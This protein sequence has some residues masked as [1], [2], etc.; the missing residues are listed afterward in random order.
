MN[1]GLWGLL[2]ALAFGG[3]D[4]CGRL[5]GRALGPRLTM[6]GVMA[7]GAVLFS[8]QAWHGDGLPA[9]S[10]SQAA[11]VVAAGLA[12]VLAPLT[13]YKALTFGPLALVGPICG[14]YPALVVPVTVLTG[15]RPGVVE[16]AAMA[17]TM[18]GVVLVARHAGDDPDAAVA[19][20]HGN[21]RRAVALAALAGVLFAAALL[22]GREAV[23]EI[24]AGATLWLGRCVGLVLLLVLVGV[25]G[26]RP[27][28]PRR[29]W[30]VVGLQGVLDAAGILA[31]YLGSQGGQAPEAA[32]ASSGFMVVAVLLGR[33]VLG[34][35]V[36]GRCWLGIALVFA[37]IATLSAGGAQ[38]TA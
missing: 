4:F 15:A 16:W 9:V 25:A 19:Q 37:G 11:W 34:E 29:W 24:G 30:A 31:F 12:A 26:E 5:T 1:G 14:A 28:L 27:R 20:G 2:A 21:R 36:P 17:V 10:A 35:K 7:V 32:V 18:A 23:T 13:L 22:L 38:A 33:V 3:A 8:P 6:L